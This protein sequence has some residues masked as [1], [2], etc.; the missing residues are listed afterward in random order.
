MKK[1]IMI[2]AL[3]VLILVI[4]GKT[5]AGI[6]Y[7][8]VVDSGDRFGETLKYAS[9]WGWDHTLDSTNPTAVPDL[10][11]ITINWAT[12]AISAYDVDYGQ[13]DKVS[14][15]GFYLGD[16]EGAASDTSHTTT[17]SIEGD[18]LAA[19]LADRSM[20]IWLDIDSAHGSTGIIWSTKIESS[21]LTVDYDLIVVPPVDPP[22]D[23]PTQPIPAP[24]AILLGS[25]GISL[26]GW[27]RRRRTL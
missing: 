14:G 6:T 22:V 17:F 13:I 11:G 9:D 24:G 10:S 16:L 25:I 26:V 19:L 18:A 5:Q 20:D 3:A 21:T 8:E 1:L 15:D 23:P 12:L 4:G 27:L 2:L 7:T